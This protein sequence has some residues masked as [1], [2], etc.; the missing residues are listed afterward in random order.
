MGAP[1][2]EV[3]RQIALD[4]GIGGIPRHNAP[5]RISQNTDIFLLLLS[6]R[7]KS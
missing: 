7:A 4:Q 2:K 5:Y 6:A 1:N 3:M